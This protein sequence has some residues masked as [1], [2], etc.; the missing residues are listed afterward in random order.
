MKYLVLIACA[1]LGLIATG[2]VK[3]E[4]WWGTDGPPSPTRDATALAAAADSTDGDEAAHSVYELLAVA[5]KAGK[6]RGSF[7]IRQQLHPLAKRIDTA[8]PVIHERVLEVGVDTSVGR[9]CRVVL[10]RMVAQQQW[11]FRRFDE[12]VTLNRSTPAA[13]RRFT[14]RQQAVNRWWAKQVAVCSVDAG[15]GQQTAVEGVLSSL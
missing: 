9:K 14:A 3:F 12:E 11:I 2:I 7:L 6:T 8:A 13:V 1:L 5:D 10:L 4:F 15:P